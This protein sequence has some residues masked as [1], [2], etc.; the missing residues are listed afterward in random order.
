MSSAT[1]D[2]H[3]VI[4]ETIEWVLGNLNTAIPARVLDFDAERQEASVQPVIKSRL[5]DGRVLSR[6]PIT[7][8]PVM[9]PAAGGGILTFPVQRGDTVLLIFS[10]RSID[11]WVQSDGGEIDPG[12]N[13]KHDISDAIAI[14]GLFPFPRA[15]SADPESV[16]I[17]FSG[18][19][20]KLAPDGSVEIQ[21]PGGLRVIGDTRIEGE[22][23]ATGEVTAKS[24]TTSIQLS[25]HTHSGIEPG[26]GVS[27]PPVP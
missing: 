19:Q 23:E 14:P 7:G 2:L 26:G 1:P 18:A 15:L 8:V 20:I 9:F 22:A 25:T 24:D 10:Q 13:R 17:K 21:A 16:I 5:K 6:A 27:G 3:Q 4:K 12:D 11:R